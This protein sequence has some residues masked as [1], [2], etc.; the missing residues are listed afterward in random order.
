VKG[1]EKAG[2]KFNMALDTDK[3]GIIER[4]EIEAAM[5]RAVAAKQATKGR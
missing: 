1:L 3:D 2:V 4:N 5:R